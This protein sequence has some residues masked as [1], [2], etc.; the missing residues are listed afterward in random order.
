MTK[1]LFTI[2]IASTLC[3]TAC[4]G[5]KDTL[6]LTRKTP[7]EFAV[8][9]RAP[10]QIPANLNQLNTLPTPQIGAPRPQ[11]TDPRLAAKQA[12]GVNT[13]APTAPSNAEQSLLSKVN[14]GDQNIRGIVDH[15]AANAGASQR[16]VIKRIFGKADSEPAATIVDPAKEKER[17]LKKSTAATPSKID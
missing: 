9:T 2:L 11:E 5:L 10:L 13:N 1:K 16:P 8:V 3:L 17:L 6:G 14:A 4:E 7:D 12:I 15:E